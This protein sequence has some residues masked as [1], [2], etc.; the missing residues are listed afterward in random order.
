MINNNDMLRVGS[1]IDD[2]IDVLSAVL[3]E[4]ITGED[5]PDELRDKIKNALL[6][7]ALDGNKS[8]IT[9]D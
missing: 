5:M 3:Y 4:G 1:M 7:N 6:E 8:Y 9:G 2:K